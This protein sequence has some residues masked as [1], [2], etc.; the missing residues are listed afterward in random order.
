MAVRACAGACMMCMDVRAIATAAT[1][2]AIDAFAP[3]VKGEH[4]NESSAAK[5]ATSVF[6]GAHM[7][8]LSETNHKT[9]GASGCARSQL[10]FV[11]NNSASPSGPDA[12]TA[13]S[14]VAPSR[15]EGRS[16]PALLK[17]L[18]IL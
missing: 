5:R 12:D 4:T 18:S 2:A 16:M 10:H 9:S 1:R 6:L 8:S 15:H 14:R 11:L 7:A 3:A 17:R 13:I